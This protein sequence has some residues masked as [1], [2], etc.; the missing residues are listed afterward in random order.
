MERRVVV[1]GVGLVTPLGV[2]T[3]RT[4]ENIC[5]GVSGVDTIT[6]FEISVLVWVVLIP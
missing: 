3:R 1:T 2:G 4:W 6:C 5:A